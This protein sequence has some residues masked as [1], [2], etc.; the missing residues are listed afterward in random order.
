M[1]VIVRPSV[2]T[3][4]DGKEALIGA[5]QLVQDVANNREWS[6]VIVG[7]SRHAIGDF[8]HGDLRRFVAVFAGVKRLSHRCPSC[9]LC[10]NK[11]VLASATWMTPDHGS[12]I[13]AW[14]D[15]A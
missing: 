11:D 6:P 9:S 5:G 3:L 1:L 8:S 15:E 2:K 14:T 7:L 4:H 12:I 10:A 13:V